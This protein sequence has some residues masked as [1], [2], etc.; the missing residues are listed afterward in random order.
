MRIALC[1]YDEHDDLASAG[2]SAHEWT[3]RGGYANRNQLNDNRYR[4]K[5]W[6]SPACIDGGQLDLF[7]DGGRG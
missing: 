6:F 4:E 5:V 1:G 2:W 3:A 7:S